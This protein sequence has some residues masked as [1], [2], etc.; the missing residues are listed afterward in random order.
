MLAVQ[1]DVYSAYDHFLAQ[2][3]V[4]A[5]KRGSSDET[6]RAGVEVLR[7]WNGQMDKDQAAPMMMELLSGQL[8]AALVKNLSQR[9]ANT[10]I[11]D[12]RPRPQVI[13]TLLRQRPPGWVAKNDWDGWLLENFQAALQEG[14]R[15]QGTPVSK[16]KWGRMLT[17]TFAHPVGKELPL[18]SRFFDLG[19]VEM[20]GSGT[21]VKQTTSTL[22]PSER[23]VVDFGDLDKSVQNLPVGESGFVASG[24][25]K[26]RMAG[27]LRRKKLP[28]AVRARECKRGA[29]G[30]ARRA[31]KTVYTIGHST[32]PADEFVKI[33]NA[34]RHRTRSGHQDRAAIG[35]EST[36]QPG[37]IRAVSGGARNRIRSL[38]SFGRTAACSKGFDQHGLGECVLSRVCGLHANSGIR[39]SD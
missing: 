3:V 23:M 8:G 11:P 22:G 6:V 30:T 39:G 21:T 10:A 37:N 35:P 2:Q 38:E 34:F 19:P 25:Y 14:R 36:I 1:K 7:R 18:V 12:I 5:S 33:L 28:D 27:V 26:D 29:D 32:R 16:W 15:R 31:V 17:W 9:A 20:S 13:E 24:H 4:A